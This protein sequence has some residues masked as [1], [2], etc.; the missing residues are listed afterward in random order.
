MEGEK[1]LVTADCCEM[2]AAAELMIASIVVKGVKAEEEVGCCASMVA[3]RW[4]RLGILC[5]I[6]E[7]TAVNVSAVFSGKVWRDDI[8][9][10]FESAAMS[11]TSK[12]CF[13]AR[14][15]R[16]LLDVHARRREGRRNAK[17]RTFD[18]IR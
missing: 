15:W 16:L 10:R 3:S 11:L 13:S 4:W 7:V 5:G 14:S 6:G 1:A 2:K 12:L 18:L 8:T 9:K 17:K